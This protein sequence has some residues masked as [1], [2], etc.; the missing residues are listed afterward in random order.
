MQYL[1]QYLSDAGR[2]E[3]A[4]AQLHKAADVKRQTLG[5]NHI[6]V[7]NVSSCSCAQSLQLGF[8]CFACKFASRFALLAPIV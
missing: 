6:E 4:L 5:K 7:A 8:A 1:G 2:H 3:E